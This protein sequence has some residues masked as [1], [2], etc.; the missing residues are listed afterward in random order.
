[1][2]QATPKDYWISATALYIELNAL[3]NPDYIQ[4]S[5][6]SG[7]VI[8]CYM[9]GIPG[10]DLDAGHNPRRWSLQASPTVFNTH[11]EKYV[12][13]AIPRHNDNNTAFVVFPSEVIDIYG[14]T[15]SHDGYDDDVIKQIGSEDYYYIYLQASLTSSG[16]NGT[17][18][19]EWRNGKAPVTGLLDTYEQRINPTDSEWY[20]YSTVSGLLTFLKNLTMKTSTLFINLFAHKLQIK[21]YG[22]EKGSITFE[23]GGGEIEKVAE[24]GSLSDKSAN[25]IATPSYLFDR[26]KEVENKYLRK[27][28]A[29]KTEFGLEMASL[30]V[31]GNAD[32]QGTHTSAQASIKGDLTMGDVDM[33]FERGIAGAAIYRDETGYHIQTDFLTVTK[34]MFATEVEVQ[35][36][37]HIGGQVML[38]AA[39]CV[40]YKAT[41]PNPTFYRVYFRSTDGE[42]SIT[43]DW[44]V[45]DLAYCKTFNIKA[46]TTDNYANTY[47]WRKVIACGT[48]NYQGERL[49]YI[50]MS[51]SACD[52]YSGEPSVDDHIVQLGNVSDA[53]RQGA[54]ILGGAGEMFGLYIFKGIN[55]FTLAN[56]LVDEISPSRVRIEANE[57]RIIVGDETKTIEDYVN[58]QGKTIVKDLESFEI[59]QVRTNDVPTLENEPYISWTEEEKVKYST[60]TTQA[61]YLNG[62]GRTWMF[63]YKDG[64]YAWEE[65][66]DPYLLAAMSK[67]EEAFANSSAEKVA[68]NVKQELA[69]KESMEINGKLESITKGTIFTLESGEMFVGTYTLQGNGTYTPTI[70]NMSGL[71]TSRGLAQIFAEGE[72]DVKAAITAYISGD[73]SGITLSADRISISSSG[74]KTGLGK[75]WSIDAYGNAVLN[76]VLAHNVTVEG[77]INNLINTID[78]ANGINADKII[79]NE[80]EDYLDILNLGDIINIQNYNSN[81]NGLYLPYYINA[82]F[83]KRTYTKYGTG[84]SHPITPAELKHL[85]GRKVTI[86][87]GSGINVNKLYYGYY[88][89]PHEGSSLSGLVN[90]TPTAILPTG[91]VMGI[92]MSAGGMVHLEFKVFQFY[93]ENKRTWT[94]GYAWVASTMEAGVNTLDTDTNWN[95]VSE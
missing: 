64:T 86:F 92:P 44:R 81:S 94:Y 70:T 85:I 68:Q 78:V 7:S 53:S 60:V 29:D 8:M 73:E 75:Y 49:H 46:G 67:A 37:S 66:T 33:P 39:S 71:L 31:N 51:A 28:Q 26:E 91:G 11:T 63:T 41:Q 1:M 79:T 25:Q 16:D 50:D 80:G 13:V 17:I 6:V 89:T 15:H 58:E 27:D 61:V 48:E 55:D 3:G 19:R 56:K 47:Y 36:V 42:K 32:V 65:F 4:A 87:F 38:T 20:Q 5:C 35:Q 21:S 93:D 77:V 18:N 95:G 14:C 45:G 57:L 72:T 2:T 84:E 9:K 43:N 69:K 10:L 40:A 62:D 24:F 76:D 88:L 74:G 59:F 34:K 22:E 12:Y 54:T 30:K 23:N 82:T 52:A 90:G 83:N